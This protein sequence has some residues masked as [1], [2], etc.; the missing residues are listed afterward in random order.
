M[1]CQQSTASARER[2]GSQATALASLWRSAGQPAHLNHRSVG[3][4]LAALTPARC[5]TQTIAYALA[6]P[7]LFRWKPAD[8]IHVSGMSADI[9]V[10]RFYQGISAVGETKSL[11]RIQH[12]KSNGWC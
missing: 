4:W 12:G 5:F 7:L 8:D 11:R 10:A 3:N 1:F 9:L 2:D 6:T